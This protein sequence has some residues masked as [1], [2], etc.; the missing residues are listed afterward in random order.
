MPST[1]ALAL[2]VALLACGGDPA[3]APAG[4]PNV[5]FD[6]SCLTATDADGDG[7]PAVA[8]GGT[9]CDDA[10]AT[11][12]PGA[13][14]AAFAWDMLPAMASYAYGPD[15]LAVGP[16]GTAHVLFR[17]VDGF[18]TLGSR[19][20]DGWTTEPVPVPGSPSTS[21]QAPLAVA[22]DGGI[23]LL[24][25]TQ[26][27]LYAAHRTAGAWSLENLTSETGAD[28]TCCL[29]GEARLAVAPDGSLWAAV[30]AV[31]PEPRLYVFHQGMEGWTLD[32]SRALRV[33][34]PT[35]DLAMDFGP[36]GDLWLLRGE[37]VDR[38]RMLTIPLIAHRTDAGW[39][40]AP[41][42]GGP[43]TVNQV[44]ADIRGF[45]GQAV[46]AVEDSTG[47]LWITTDGVTQEAQTLPGTGNSARLVISGTPDAPEVSYLTYRDPN[48]GTVSLGRVGRW[49]QEE[50]PLEQA[51][52]GAG[53]PRAL[54]VDDAGVLHAVTEYAIA[55]EE[56]YRYLA[57][58]A[59]DSID[60]DCDGQPDGRSG[61]DPS[62]ATAALD[63]GQIDQLCGWAT[64]QTAAIDTE[65]C[66]PAVEPTT[67]AERVVMCPTVEDF[68]QCQLAVAAGQCDATGGLGACAPCVSPVDGSRPT[69]A[70]TDAETDAVCDWTDALDHET[71]RCPLAVDA[72]SCVDRLPMCPD[73]ATFD[74]CQLALAQ[75][76]CDTLLLPAECEACTAA[77]EAPTGVAAADL[78]L[79][80]LTALQW[81]DLCA[82]STAIQGGS[83]RVWTCDD[84]TVTTGSEEE[85]RALEDVINGNC[86]AT[87]GDYEDCVQAIAA[88]PC[89]G[90]EAPACDALVSCLW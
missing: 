30:L 54:V 7:V 11:V 53:Y 58:Q 83:G 6:P 31:A 19:D 75:T 77:I 40:E 44:G 3:P 8:C 16:D 59:P 56:P 38:I 4:D 61:L 37:W 41:A 64:E 22:P 2:L 21:L 33:A 60:Q 9:D 51:V 12:H 79:W 17:N 39:T 88:D 25:L 28:D 36:D 20:A 89:G 72:G 81:G 85:C 62:L 55:S 87:V 69:D 50:T 27:A 34:D 67:C 35:F 71:D 10:D 42:P 68:E 46:A 5:A 84:G 47:I 18:F 23:H 73:V 82:W 76:G 14:D 45:A 24:V 86:R 74:A 1:P 65:T 80:Q 90:F 63:D 66:W 70:L 32:D 26:G 48:E 57:Y 43:R 49:G 15:D 29:Q 78:A 13:K 52:V